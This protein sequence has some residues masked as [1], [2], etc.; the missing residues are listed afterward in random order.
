HLPCLPAPR[1]RRRRHD[2][3]SVRIIVAL[4]LSF[5]DLSTPLLPFFTPRRSLP[6]LQ[7]RDNQAA[8]CGADRAAGGGGALGV[9][10]V[11]RAA[12]PRRCNAAVWRHPLRVQAR[13]GGAPSALRHLPGGEAVRFFCAPFV[14]IVTEPALP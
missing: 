3:L 13:G 8:G 11:E 10:A 14:I 9:S 4:C 6:S 2:I 1:S 5:L 12:H 7:A